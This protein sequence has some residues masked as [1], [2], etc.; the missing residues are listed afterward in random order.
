MKCIE[1]YKALVVKELPKNGIVIYV[2]IGY[3]SYGKL[4][5]H[6]TRQP[7]LHPVI[8]TMDSI[9]EPYR[10]DAHPEFIANFYNWHKLLDA[11]LI[12]IDP[13]G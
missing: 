7:L 13:V 3:D 4:H 9:I 2:S 8:T 6:Y 11:E 1:R 10:K 12:M 5:F